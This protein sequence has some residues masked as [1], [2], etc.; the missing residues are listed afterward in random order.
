MGQ[1]N[2]K[3]RVLKV[4]NGHYRDHRPY[5]HIYIYAMV[6]PYM[7]GYPDTK[8]P[9]GTSVKK[10]QDIR[11]SD[12]CEPSHTLRSTHFTLCISPTTIAKAQNV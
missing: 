7:I 11:M 10:R 8:C 5:I 12:V 2:D 9:R 1:S 4:Y 6:V 3:E